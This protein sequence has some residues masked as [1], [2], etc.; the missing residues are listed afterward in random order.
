MVTDTPNPQTPAAPDVMN[1][2]VTRTLMPPVA[3]VAN[4]IS[5][6][7]S[8]LASLRVDLVRL[9]GKL[10]DA[11]VHLWASYGLSLVALVVALIALLRT[12]R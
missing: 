11:V 5:L 7:A 3:N 1:T 8:A 6:P 4:S 2:T 9:E 12:Y 10:K